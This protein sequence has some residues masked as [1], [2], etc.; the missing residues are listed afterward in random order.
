MKHRKF[1]KDILAG[2]PWE[3]QWPSGYRFKSSFREAL[4]CGLSASIPARLQGDYIRLFALASLCLRSKI[5]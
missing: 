2:W 3:A 4:H 1:F 5:I